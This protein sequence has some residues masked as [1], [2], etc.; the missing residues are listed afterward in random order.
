MWAEQMRSANA[1]R[2]GRSPAHVTQTPYFFQNVKWVNT[3]GS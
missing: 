1:K 3:F 2:Q